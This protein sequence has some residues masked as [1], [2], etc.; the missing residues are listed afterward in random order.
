MAC[1]YWFRKS[2]RLHDNPSLLNVIGVSKKLVPIFIIDPWFRTSGRVGALRYNFLVETLIHLDQSLKKLGSSLVVLEGQPSEV[3]SKIVGKSNDYDVECVAWEKDSEPFSK[4]RDSAV[5]K[6]LED[7]GVSVMKCSGHTL[8]DLDELRQLNPGN[9]VTTYG[10]FEKLTAKKGLPKRPLATP[11]KLPVMP[12]NWPWVQE[13]LSSNPS[14]QWREKYSLPYAEGQKLLVE[15]GEE[16][17]LVKMRA[18]CTSAVRVAHFSKPNTD[19]TKSWHGTD[20]SKIADG[21]TTVLSPHLHFGSLSPR[22][23]YWHLEDT[24]K[25]SKAK[26]ATKPPVSLVGQ[27]LWREFF[28]Y[29]GC[30]TP[31]FDRI[32]G[33]SIC[34]Q[35]PWKQNADHFE[36]WKNAR[37]GYPWIDAIMTQL[38]NEGWIHHLAR[39]CVACFLTRG[40]LYLPWPDG[41]RVFEE[42]LLDADWSLNAANWMWLSCSA[43]YNQYWKVYS[44]IAFP[45]KYDKEGVYVKKYLPMLKNYPAKYIYEPWKAPKVDQKKW[46]CII[47][48]DYPKPIVEHDVASKACKESFKKFFGTSSTTDANEDM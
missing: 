18:Y 28:H 14:S 5:E 30:F 22:V 21:A 23:F 6:I 13:A 10:A 35:I 11:E 4:A 43:F 32:E 26:D 36:A 37:T 45:K 25:A 1:I 29:V 38:R 12:S 2:L 46:G 47:G 8:Y 9:V 40:D 3:F 7:A 27:L 42:L 39:H 24:V 15:A 20:G 41:E 19:P 16:S 17:A 44:P 31:N 33:N 48:Q 34:R